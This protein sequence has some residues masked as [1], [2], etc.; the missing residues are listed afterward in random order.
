MEFNKPEALLLTGNISENFKRFKHEIQIYFLATETNKKSKE[1]QVARL[2]NLLGSDGNRLLETFNIEHHRVDEILDALEKYCIPRRNE[3]M[4]NFQFFTRKQQEG[5]KFDQFYADLRKLARICDFGQCEKKLLKTQIVLGI[6][7]K[8]LQTRLLREDPTLDNVIKYCQL[9]EQAEINRRIVQEE[10]SSEINIVEQAPHRRNY[11]QY[12]KNKQNKNTN[13]YTDWKNNEGDHSKQT[14]NNK[15]NKNVKKQI[16]NCNRCGRNHNLNECPAFGQ[17]CKGCGFLNHFEI[18]C[19]NKDKHSVNT[20]V[21]ETL[22]LSLITVE[23]NEVNK[24]HRCWTDKLLIENIESEVKLDTG[25][26]INV[27]PISFFK[28]LNK[29]AQKSNL[30]ITAFGGFK[31]NSVG[32]VKLLV[33]SQNIK[34][35][36]EFEIVDYIGLPIISYNDCIKFKFNIP[37]EINL[38]KLEDKEKQEFIERNK[39]VFEGLGNFPDK[40]NIKLIKEAIPKSCPPRRVP[41][42]IY[43]RIQETLDRMEKLKIIKRTLE[44]SEWQSNMVTVEK[45]D[46]TL[47]ICIDPRELNKVIIKD[48][49]QIPSL[50]ELRPKLANKK[51]YTLLD[52]K[53][54]YHQCELDQ[55]SQKYCSFSTPFGTYQFLR[56]PFGLSSAPEKFQELIYKYFG[57]IKNVSVYF[58]DILIS[59]TTKAEHDEILNEVIQQARI[60]NIKFNPKKLQLRVTKVKFL[61]FIFDEKGVHPDPDR[62]Q[63]IQNLKEP[64]NKKELQSFLGMVNYLRDFI[65]NMSEISSS[66]RLLLKKNIIWSWDVHCQGSFN[67]LKDILSGLPTLSNFNSKIGNLEIQCDA[68]Q[69]AVGCCLFQNKKPIYFASRSL[70]ETEIGYAQIEKEMLAIT[71]A[72]SKFHYLIYGQS[73]VKVFT[74]HK[75]LVSIMSKEMHKIPNNR[76]RRLLIKLMIYDLSVNYLPGNQMYVADYLSRNY[77]V[78]KSNV[79]VDLEDTVHIV[80]EIDIDFSNEKEKEFIQA[81]ESDQN[82]NK[83]KQFI[84]TGWPANVKNFEGELKHFSKIKN[85]LL[86]E[87]NLIYYDMRLVVPKLLRQYIIKK[88]HETH[89]GVVK[90]IEKAKTVFYWPGMSSNIQNYISACAVCLK[91]S[92]NKVKEPLLSHSIPDFPFLKIGID[93]AEIGGRA[94]L[95][96]MD[97]YSRWLEI[98]KIKQKT[99]YAVIKKLKKIFSRF[100]IPEVVV[101]DN[102]PCGSLEFKKFASEWNF[103]IIN[104]SPNYPKS[105]GLAE[106]AVGIAKMLIKKSAH[107]KQDLELYLLDYRN[108]P[109]TGLQCTPAQLLQSRELRS[110]I[111]VVH[112]KELFKPII[113]NCVEKMMDSKRKQALYY[114]RGANK[115]ISCFEEGEE[116]YIQDKF[117]KNWHDGIII[118][119]LNEPRS[120]LVKDKYGRTLRRNTSFLK[121]SG[122][123]NNKVGEREESF[124]SGT[125][126][127]YNKIS[128]ITNQKGYKTRVG[129]RVVKPKKFDL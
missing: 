99:S 27:L 105:N 11:K 24:S 85:E 125:I 122:K 84:K 63:S 75:P 6:T 26:Q 57:H 5:E 28:K 49:Y 90:T 35:E 29:T 65:P 59:A 60:L 2:L 73:S 74:D 117:T 8:E 127:H 47:R 104:S 64:T 100:G 126:E 83:I 92:R 1:I 103:T 123:Q 54:G 14:G 30:V 53:D 72:C 13:T 102:N 70:S 45:P 121:K 77:I 129:R 89:L 33:Q 18:K 128:R 118:K 37:T 61:G 81:T 4:E 91:F 95:I 96:V 120:Y 15:Y 16:I 109:I 3:I 111:N 22:N 43:D 107:E 19:R 94:Y 32:K 44:P 80:N 46:K 124:K 87:N 69:G 116:V 66:L 55:N 50:E 36:T 25:A 17:E 101:A 97:Y 62:I 7:D 51:Y 58:D 40:I 112:R 71:Y 119:K 56:L 88:L 98:R 20:M 67:R 76:L 42:K 52:L 108:A 106:K 78:T 10:A 79:D 21:T 93:I 41:I 86:I 9:V 23:I 12:T 114:N 31:I 115:N 48:R 82:L 68:S 39:D 110:K 34:Y 113:Q 38:V